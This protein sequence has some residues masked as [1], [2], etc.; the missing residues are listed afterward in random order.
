MCDIRRVKISVSTK[1]LH[2]KRPGL[3]PIFDSEVESQYYPRWCPSVPGRL[4]GDYA[5]ALIKL[6][7]RDM[8]SVASELRELQKAL[9]EN[10]TPLTPCR[11]LNALTWIAKAGYEDW[12]VEQAFGGTERPAVVTPPGHRQ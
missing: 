4:W 12:I 5:V 11:I 8:L 9:E 7:H 3:I 1:I 2:K 10:G 6:V